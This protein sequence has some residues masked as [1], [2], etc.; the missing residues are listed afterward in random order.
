MIRIYS[1]KEN[2]KPTSLE[3]LIEESGEKTAY[4]TTSFG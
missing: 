4:T 1:K 2:E 3:G